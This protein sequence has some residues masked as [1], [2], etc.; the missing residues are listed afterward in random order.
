MPIVNG[1]IPPLFANSF[2]AKSPI[3]STRDNVTIC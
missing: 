1:K 2:K 3:I